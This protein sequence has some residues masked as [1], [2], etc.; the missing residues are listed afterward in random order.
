MGGIDRNSAIARAVAGANGRVT[1]LRARSTTSA[2]SKADEIA[3]VLGW[4][5]EHATPSGDMLAK[6]KDPVW[7]LSF[8]HASAEGRPVLFVARHTG[9]AADLPALGRFLAH[10]CANAD[11][12]AHWGVVV[13]TDGTG[14][15]CEKEVRDAVSHMPIEVAMVHA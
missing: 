6:A 11:A 15:D 9:D 8:R 10:V 2:A 3:T 13:V 5:V 7:L 1:M 12:N 4:T 14:E